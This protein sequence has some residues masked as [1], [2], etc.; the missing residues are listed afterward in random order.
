MS[1]SDEVSAW[2]VPSVDST[3]P[4]V[5]TVG[6]ADKTVLRNVS[7]TCKV[8]RF[9]R[10]AATSQSRVC[11]VGWQKQQKAACRWASAY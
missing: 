6:D 2:L 8:W 7:G 3:Q 10:S 11:R 9:D 5:F 4:Q 1:K